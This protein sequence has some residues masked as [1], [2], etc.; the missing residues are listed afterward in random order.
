MTFIERSN[1]VIID[2]FIIL[3]NESSIP[4][5]INKALIQIRILSKYENVSLPY[6]FSLL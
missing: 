1:I 5:N 6:L 4:I 3:F 2:E